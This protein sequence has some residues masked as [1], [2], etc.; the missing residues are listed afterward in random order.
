MENT[1]K[2]TY[3]KGRFQSDLLSLEN[4]RHRNEVGPDLYGILKVGLERMI[5]RLEEEYCGENTG[6]C[7]P[8]QEQKD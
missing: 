8:Q 1:R 4:Q 7:E 5:G 6:S 2:G 3:W